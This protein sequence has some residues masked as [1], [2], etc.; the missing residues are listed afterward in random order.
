M[1][2]D[3]LDDEHGV[4]VVGSVGGVLK[5]VAKPNG[6][7]EFIVYEVDVSHKEQSQLEDGVAV[8]N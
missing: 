6:E 2:K 4:E 8:V 5:E 3:A 1:R 7:V